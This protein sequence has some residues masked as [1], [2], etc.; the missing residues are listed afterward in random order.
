MNFANV[1]VV[2]EIG[3]NHNQDIQRCY[4]LIGQAADAGC[5]GVKVQLFDPEKFYVDDPANAD[6]INELRF[7]ALPPEWLP[8][9]KNCCNKNGVKL[10]VSVF[11]LAGVDVATHHADYLKIASYSLPYTAL[12][13]KAA[14]SSIVSLHI[15]TGLATEHE[16]R[17]AY[18]A[19]AVSG[20]A[21]YLYYCAAKYPASVDE[22]S[23]SQ[24][25][26]IV[27]S[28]S[29]NEIACSGYSDHTV[30]TGVVLAA[31]GMGMQYIECH[32][33]LSDGIGFESQHGHCWPMRK[34]RMLLETIWDFESA[35]DREAKKK[36]LADK[37]LRKQRVNARDG[38]RPGNAAPVARKPT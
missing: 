33:D 17:R 6:L 24:M 29:R 8:L 12:V 36:I 18:I 20:N 10:G 1:R 5:W 25:P 37:E 32:V 19:A 11:D 14:Q 4:R 21:P 2:A 13:R 34:F 7:H 22:V 15:S 31:V 27:S 38:L 16:I 23:F 35:M 3:A 9:I 28:S 30:N 26:V